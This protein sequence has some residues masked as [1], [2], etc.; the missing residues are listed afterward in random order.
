MAANQDERGFRL[1]GAVL[2]KDMQ[3]AENARVSEGDAEG[4][5]SD[6]SEGNNERD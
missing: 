5:G 4:E 1:S 3:Q 2:G 6:D